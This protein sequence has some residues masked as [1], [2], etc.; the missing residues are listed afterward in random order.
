MS[1]YTC[2]KCEKSLSSK[3]YLHK[4][5]EKCNGLSKLQCELCH[6][7]FKSVK[8]KYRHKKEKICEKNGTIIVNADNSFNT[9]NNI[10][11][12]YKL[13]IM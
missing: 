12:S 13:I 2:S 5:E 10:T 9:T 11:D 4:H 3:N 8:S 6:K 7:F 1:I